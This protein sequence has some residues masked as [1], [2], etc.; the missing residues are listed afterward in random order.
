MKSSTRIRIIAVLVILFCAGLFVRLFFLQVVKKQYYRDQ[1]DR[2]YFRPL[3]GS[4]D[5][6]TIYLRSKDGGLVAAATTREGYT[7][8][9]NPKV[10]SNATTTYEKLSGYF[11]QAG[12][13]L[14]KELFFQKAAK[15]SDPYEEISTRADKGL[16]DL[17]SSVSKRE[18]LVSKERWRYYPASTTAA[19]ALGLLGYL[20]E[21]YSGRYGLEKSY[22]DVLSRN[23]EQS[24][25]NFFAEI[26]RGL[27]SAATSSDR[28]QGD[29]VL[30]IEP[31]VQKYLEA[32]LL[33]TTQKY[34][35]EMAGGIVMDPQTG[36]IYALAAWPNF[37]PG[38]KV[39]DLS[40]L[41]NLLVE[42]RYE[43]GSI[44][45]ALTMATGLDSGAVRATTTY[46]DK[47]CLTLNKKLFCNYDGKARGV[48][49]MQEVLN[50]S[51]NLGAT[52]VE[53]RV[54][55]EKFKQYFAA[56]GLGTK[57]GIDLPGEVSGSL[58]TLGNDQDVEFATASFGQGISLTPMA[59]A[60]ALAT[61]GNGG[62]LVQ[63]HLVQEIRY[64]TGLKKVITPP[65]GPQVIATAT[66]RE[67]TRMLSIVVDTK[68]AN[69]KAKLPHTTIAAK[70]GTAQYVDPTTKKY[71]PDR[72]LHSFFGYFPAYEPRFLVFLMIKHPRGVE[73]ASETLTEPFL[74]MSKFL[75]S[76]YQVPPDR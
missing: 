65:L 74:E 27:A 46:N 40:V 56:F 44:V 11:A 4:F 8:A 69:G 37:N 57:T 2:Q 61:L 59:M 5:R 28:A 1:A 16:A 10:I 60:R 13:P 48:V 55:K 22:N 66:S 20:G 6:G 33:K 19:H 50:Q 9:I 25:A 76:Y 38:E 43:L 26:Y 47:G 3:A 73:Y 67:I 29:I 30:T 45:K 39:T 24:F 41:P 42:G 53:Q 64:T 54:G 72:Y 21:D 18:V 51:L 23:K 71:Y 58:A 63:P 52:F 70:T 12:R 36:A 68:L 32:E 75:L 14:D 34:S 62:Y 17:A 35:P 31:T 49:G 15:K 7:I